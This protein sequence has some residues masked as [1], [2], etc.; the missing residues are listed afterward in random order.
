M[1]MFM[2]EKILRYDAFLFVSYGFDIRP[3][4]FF[5]RSYTCEKPRT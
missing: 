5:I 2:D 4:V 1:Q 3:Q